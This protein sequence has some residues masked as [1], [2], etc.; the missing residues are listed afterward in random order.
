MN[1]TNKAMKESM[2]WFKHN[3]N[4]SWPTVSYMR[5]DKLILFHI[6]ALQIH[7]F[8]ICLQGEGNQYQAKKK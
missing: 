5:Y 7:L 3:V 6:D 1:K 2:I 8:V 4:R